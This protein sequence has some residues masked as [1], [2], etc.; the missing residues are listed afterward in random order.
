MERDVKIQKAFE[1]NLVI[2]QMFC[3]TLPVTSHSLGITCQFKTLHIYRWSVCGNLPP[4]TFATSHVLGV[5]WAQV[6]IAITPPPF[7]REGGEMNCLL[8]Q[9]RH[10]PSP[11]RAVSPGKVPG[12]QCQTRGVLV[13]GTVWGTQQTPSTGRNAGY[14]PDFSIDYDCLK[15]G[16]KQA[17]GMAASEAVGLLVMLSCCS[18]CCWLNV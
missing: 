14:F 17:A 6:P 13:L 3:K 4:M 12:T 16:S 2:L 7:W 15:Q 11:A 10:N 1:F 9:H 18:S 8:T 5:S